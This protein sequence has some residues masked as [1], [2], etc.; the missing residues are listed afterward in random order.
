LISDVFRE[1]HAKI[2][3][4]AVRIKVE[5]LVSALQK[6]KKKGPEGHNEGSAA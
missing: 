6:K 5:S 1:N 3:G 2:R 4:K